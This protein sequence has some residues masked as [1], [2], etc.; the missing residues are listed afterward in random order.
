M[1]IAGST[2]EQTLACEIC[3]IAVAHD[4]V[5]RWEYG[6][7]GGGMGLYAIV[8]GGTG[9]CMSMLIGWYGLQV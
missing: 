9:V 4:R 6:D 1:V 2:S 5:G 3:A 7:T 8:F